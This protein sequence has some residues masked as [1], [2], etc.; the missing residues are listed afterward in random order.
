MVRSSPARAGDLSSIPG[1]RRSPGKG[2]GNPLL[3]SCLENPHGTE[4][5]RKRRL[6]KGWWSR[7]THLRDKS[8][9][10]FVWEGR[11]PGGWR[12]EVG[13]GL[14]SFWW[15]REMEAYLVLLEENIW[16]CG[17]TIVTWWGCKAL[18]RSWRGL[19]RKY[20]A[21]WTVEKVSLSELGMV[22]VELPW[23]PVAAG[24]THR[25]WESDLPPHLSRS[26]KVWD[27][28]MILGD[29]ILQNP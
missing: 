22:G 9:Q 16:D 25:D 8:R 27:S 28:C 11:D 15:R 17:R 3:C 12:I 7:R 6:F 13:S 26:C 20:L 18:K 1:S 10:V 14:P 19:T 29:G 24:T 23:K 4:C 2:N 5:L 21:T